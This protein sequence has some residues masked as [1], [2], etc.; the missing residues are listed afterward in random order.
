MSHRVLRKRREQQSHWEK[1][2]RSNNLWIGCPL[3]THIHILSEDAGIIGENCFFF[4]LSRLFFV[5]FIFPFLLISR[6]LIHKFSAALTWGEICRTSY[7]FRL[8]LTFSFSPTDNLF[9]PFSLLTSPGES[10]KMA[11]Q[12]RNGRTDDK[13]RSNNASQRKVLRRQCSMW[14]MARDVTWWWCV[15]LEG[16]EIGTAKGSTSEL[17]VL[18]LS[19]TVVVLIVGLLVPFLC[20]RL[21]RSRMCCRMER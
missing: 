2:L 12:C 6:S 16:I 21:R 20:Y 19:S 3:C 9:L 14:L 15:Q 18:S 13:R 17:F 11:R 4:P 8:R 10:N 1:S 5:P 7:L